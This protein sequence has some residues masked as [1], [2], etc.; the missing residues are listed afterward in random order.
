MVRYFPQNKGQ[1]GGNAQ[2]MS[3]PQG[4]AAAKH[5]KQNKFY[6]MKGREKLE[7]KLFKRIF[8]DVLMILIR[9]KKLVELT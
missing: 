1:I 3:N 6:A 7:V 5:P 4:A 8:Q 2:P 9:A